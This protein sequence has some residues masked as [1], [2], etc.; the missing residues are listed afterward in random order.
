MAESSQDSAP[1]LERAVLLP[2]LL[3]TV[4]FMVLA[5][6]LHFAAF[7]ELRAERAEARAAE[8]QRLVTG[9]ALQFS[10]PSLEAAELRRGEFLARLNA[11]GEL[12]QE[13]HGPLP[14]FLE[15]GASADDAVRTPASLAGHP[16]LEAARDTSADSGVSRY[17]LDG[18]EWIAVF[19]KLPAGG[20]L[21]AAVPTV[22]AVAPVSE[23]QAQAMMQLFTAS[24]AFF[25]LSN[26]LLY[27][28]RG[29]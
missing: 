6:A 2:G 25:L 29:R 7:A 8:L 24:F 18:L 13:T 1:R 9:L 22:E 27:F 16:A 11:E 19:R 28:Y 5:F 21:V 14:P 20:A 23:L 4:A 15:P 12:Q 10:G 3:L 26:G 17:T